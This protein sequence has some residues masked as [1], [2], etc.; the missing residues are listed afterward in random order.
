MK[1]NSLLLGLLLLAVGG[2]CNG[3][4]Y[5]PSSP[6]FYPS[7]SPPFTNAGARLPAVSKTLAA[8]PVPAAVTQTANEASL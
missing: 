1:R 3:A 7:G 5:G 4:Y 6:D 8:K 2:G